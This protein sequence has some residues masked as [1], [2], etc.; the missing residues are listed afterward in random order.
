MKKIKKLFFNTI[1]LTLTSFIMQTVSVSFNV[2]LTN[3]IGSAG[4]GLFQLIMTVYAMSITFSCGGVRLATTRLTID[5]LAVESSASAKNI[6]NCCIKYSLIISLVISI[7]VFASADLISIHWLYDEKTALPLRILALCLPFISMSSALK[8]YFT[9]VRTVFKIAAVQGFEQALKIIIV[10]FTLD[11]FL[12]KGIEYACVSIVLGICLSEI[13]SFIALYVLYK[14]SKT[15][16]KSNTEL[17]PKENLA[18]LLRIAVPDA[19]GACARS[20]LLTI[21]H[22][23]IPIGFKKSGSSPEQSLSTYG[24]IHGMVF[25]VL[26]YPSAI[27]VSLSG[28]LVPELAESN[29]Q[30]NTKHIEYIIRRVLHMTLIYS[31]CVAAIIFSF[32]NELSLAIYNKTES[33][34]YIALLSMLIPVM[35]MD[36]SVDG[37][38]KGLNQ[39][40]YTMRYNIIDSALCVI[41]VYILIPKYSVKAYIFILFISEIINF[42]LSIR[43]LIVISNV[44]LKIVNSVVKPCICVIGS[45]ALVKATVK[46]IGFVDTQTTISMVLMKFACVI[47]YL[48]ALFIFSSITTND[49]K[50]FKSILSR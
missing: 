32:S 50:W 34:Q 20:I 28:L 10:V 35:Y 27:L 17:K 26:L 2:Y 23:L 9:A 25:P 12:P 1:L 49:I 22:L 29:A 40:F 14:F 5:R 37:I 33:T 8:G 15:A 30:N 39:Q 18:K 11:I 13:A 44:K 3:K 6:M 21:E 41:L 31:I 48:F 24:V 43:R 42:F 47:I 38:L 36:M 45:V 4:I 46:M 7:I 16:Y 19:V